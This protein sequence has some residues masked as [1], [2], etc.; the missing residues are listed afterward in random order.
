MMTIMQREKVSLR[1]RWSYWFDG[2]MSRGTG[3]I[4]GLLAITTALFVVVLGGIAWLVK[5]LIDPNSAA[6]DAG[7][8]PWEYLWITLMRTLDA[9]SVAGDDGWW[10]RLLML[11]A[12]IGGLVIVASLIGIIAGAFN[13]KVAQLRLG[14]SKVLEREH[15]LILGWNNKIFTI[16]RELAVAN[17][18][19]GRTAIVILANQDKVEMEE[20]IHAAVPQ[21][22]NT[23]LVCR[24]GDPKLARDIEIGNPQFAR[25]IILLA[26]SEVD[27]PDNEV[28]KSALALTNQT[29]CLACNKNIVAELLN[30][31]NLSVAQLAGQN[32]IDWIT[33][34]DFI[35]RIIAQ[36]CRQSGLSV[37]YRELLA[38]EG[39]EFYFTNQP[40]LVG[41]T[42]FEAQLAFATST[43]VGIVSEGVVLVNPPATT[44]INEGEDL[45]VIAEDDSTISIADPAVFDDTGINIQKRAPLTPE[46]VAILGGNRGLNRILS[47]LNDYVAAGSSVRLVTDVKIPDLPSLNNLAIEM[48]SLDPTQHSTLEQLG[49][50]STE[51]IIV[52]PDKDTYPPAK[53]DDRTLV[54]LLMLRDLELK[55]GVQLAIVSEMLDDANR[56]LAEITEADDFIVSDQLVALAL[57]QV[58]EDQQIKRLYDVLFTAE[59][60]EIYLRPAEN[61]VK[62]G[63]EVSFA[64]TLEAARRC[65]ET[66][67]GYRLGKYSNQA[68]K[69]YG[70]QINPPKA[71]PLVFQ[72]GDSIIVLAED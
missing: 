14:R 22:G 16:V 4:M 6:P 59:G 58:S 15:T 51:H 29:E 53:A 8:T 27:E 3:A 63:V 56:E 7:Q 28:I 43:L 71:E 37:V 45:I 54:I 18:S 25:S 10:F 23:K 66:A 69:H 40:S 2:W 11:L 34:Q 30:E 5:L 24:T 46:H 67:I 26:P 32:T 41:K 35:D 49:L 17:E 60:S 36:S 1:A 44:V 48:I 62:L 72:P 31:A 47:E 20:A 42:F 57:A 70:V 38:F 61:Y 65:E 50:D 52:I 21:L 33:G 68:D 13:A 55:Q 12:T 9:S 39:H 64:T 19:R